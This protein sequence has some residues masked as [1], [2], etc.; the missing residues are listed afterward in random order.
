[1]RPTFVAQLVDDR[2]AI[3]AVPPH[4]AGSMLRRHGA[5]LSASV[6]LR[7]IALA[8]AWGRTPAARS[9]PGPGHLDSDPDSNASAGRPGP[10]CDRSPS[11]AHPAGCRAAEYIQ[12][13]LRLMLVTRSSMLRLRP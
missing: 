7:H 6:L 3:L 2:P 12:S 5:S 13:P 1:M 8:G 11:G 4:G 10:G 9:G